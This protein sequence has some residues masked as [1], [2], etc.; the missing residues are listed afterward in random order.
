[1]KR[2]RGRFQVAFKQR[3]PY[4]GSLPQTYEKSA[5]MKLPHK[6]SECQGTGC[7]RKPLEAPDGSNFLF[8]RC[9]FCK[10]KGALSDE[11]HQAYLKRQQTP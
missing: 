1:M 3:F 10:G 7:D 5:S 8:P 4:I 6:C 11:Q 2:E 9:E